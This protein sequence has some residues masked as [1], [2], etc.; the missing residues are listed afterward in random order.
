MNI[1]GFQ[2]IS[3]LDYPGK[4]A[5]IIW[6]TGCNF[7]CPFCYNPSLV[8]DNTDHVSVDDFFSF[9]EKRKGKLDA[10]SISGG[11][12][13]LQN[14]IKPFITRIK[15]LGFLVKIDTNGSFPK[16]LKEL[17]DENLIDYVSMDVK[18]IKEKYSKNTGVS[19]D[20]D[21][22]DESI[23]IIK[24]IAPDYEFKT[25]VIPLFHSD[26]DILDIA[27][28]LEGSKRYFLQQFKT[29]TPLLSKN[30]SLMK[31]YSK[32]ELYRM[33]EMIKPF[34]KECAVRGI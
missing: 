27:G 33:C 13:F 31:S 2:E 28:W 1:G 18:N 19:M 4:I 16:E 17:L 9:L 5:T 3:L 15:S 6:T 10:I 8:L 23:C 22:I 7:R 12:P 21:R 26:Q 14:D 30:G 32:D 20:I 34:F 25:T 11:E 24:D 29:N